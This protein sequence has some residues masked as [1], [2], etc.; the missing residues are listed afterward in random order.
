MLMSIRSAPAL[1]TMCVMMF[2]TIRHETLISLPELFLRQI[3]TF[4]TTLGTGRCDVGKGD[5]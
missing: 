4:P 1:A 3:F 5:P 2:I